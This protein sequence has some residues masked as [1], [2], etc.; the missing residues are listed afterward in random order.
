MGKN[1]GINWGRSKNAPGLKVLLM[2]ALPALANAQ[3]EED[4]QQCLVRL[5]DEARNVGVSE[6]TIEQVVPSL[7]K[8]ERVVELDR[9]QPEFVQTFGQYL[10]ARVTQARIERGRELFQQHR[11]FLDDLAD[12]YGIPGQYLV[13]FWGLETNFGSY[14]GTMPTLDSL[15]TLACDPRRSGFF[16]GEFVT[17]LR[18]MEREKLSPQIMKGSWAGAVGHTQFMPSSYLRY[19]V[20]GDGDGLV[21]L[22]ASERDALASGANFL[23]NLGW[24]PGERWGR[25]IIL[26]DGFDYFSAGLKNAKALQQWSD[27]GVRTA[28]GAQLPQADFEGAVLVPAGSQGPAFLVY[29]NFEVIMRW[30]RSESY[31]LSVGLLADRIAGAGRLVREPGNEPGVRFEDIGRLQASLQSLGYDPG[32]VDGIWGPST[33]QALSAWQRDR[34]EIA[35]G[36]AAP[37]IVQRVIDEASQ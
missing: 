36:Y 10:S 5:Q 8:Q 21:N 37:V 16:T 28:S 12:Q 24:R 33:R 23:A 17:A 1:T 20:D 11:T 26:P 2:A 14:L 31:A 34:G 22:W 15:A 29:D 4:F 25:E 35:D 32:P 13:A 3:L 7:Q 30:N 18:L 27:L 9:S 19:A 6:Q